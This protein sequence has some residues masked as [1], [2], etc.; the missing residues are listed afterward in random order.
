MKIMKHTEKKASGAGVF[1]PFLFAEYP[2]KCCSI[3]GEKQ[4]SL[5]LLFHLY[6]TL[7]LT[8]ASAS[9]APPSQGLE[10]HFSLPQCV[11]LGK[12][13]QQGSAFCL[14]LKEESYFFYFNFYFILEYS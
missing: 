4:S 5:K 8:M 11:I 14:M 6:T 13:S 9:M 7:A 12:A 2:Q 3:I 1:H 10:K